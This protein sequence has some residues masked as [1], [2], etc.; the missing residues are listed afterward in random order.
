MTN[1][2]KIETRIF[3][4]SS[5]LDHGWAS[6]YLSHDEINFK[7]LQE[8]LKLSTC[9]FSLHHNQRRIEHE[10]QRNTWFCYDKKTILFSLVWKSNLNWLVFIAH[11]I[12]IKVTK[13]FTWSDLL[14][15]YTLI[16]HKIFAIR[17]RQLSQV[18][19]LY[20]W[21]LMWIFICVRHRERMQDVKNWWI[22][23]L[24]IEKYDMK[25]SLIMQILF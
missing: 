21:R 17:A 7:N 20:M 13:N 5:N 10:K 11:S 2:C 4:W 12:K 3:M 22:L 25:F 18:A 16:S 1:I 23:F 15:K 6:N 24:I 19:K 14:S 9:T 8:G